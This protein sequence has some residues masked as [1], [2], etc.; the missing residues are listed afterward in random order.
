MKTDA[1][2]EEKRA[3]RRLYRNS[4]GTQ[5]DGGPLANAFDVTQK[6]IANT[7]VLVWP[8]QTQ[9]DDETPKLLALWEAAQPH[10]LNPTT[11]ETEG[12]D[13]INGLLR[14]GA[15]FGTG[16]PDLDRTLSEAGVGVGGKVLA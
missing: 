2:V 7:N 16:I 14:P 10:R 3:N 5:R 4:F 15:P 1:Y 11:L 9:Q 6:N 12:V 8:T 13:Y